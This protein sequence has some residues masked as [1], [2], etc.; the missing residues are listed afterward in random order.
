MIKITPTEFDVLARHILNISGIALVRGKEYL[1]ETRLSPLLEALA[2]TSYTELQARIKADYKGE[3]N[4]KVI[5]AISTNETY[6]FRDKAPFELLQHKIIPDL[7]DSRTQ[8]KGTSKP[9]IRLWSA[10]SSTGQEIYSI[11][12]ALN[13]IGITPQKYNI[14][15]N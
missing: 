3:I 10:A 13:E 1:V 15:L 6:F 14:L 5:D 7:M 11:A 4:E 12:M 2:C 9:S 8:N